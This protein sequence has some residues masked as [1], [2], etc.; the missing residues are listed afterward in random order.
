MIMKRKPVAITIPAGSSPGLT[1]TP[2]LSLCGAFNDCSA[3]KNVPNH[4]ETS[5]EEN[6]TPS[7]KESKGRHKNKKTSPSGIP[8]PSPTGRTASVVKC[9]RVNCATCPVFRPSKYFKSSLTNR[10]YQVVGNRNLSCFTSNLVY[11]ITCS[12]CDNQYVGE[13]KQKLSKRLSRHRSAI[14][15]HAYTFIAKHF[16]QPEHSVAD[17]LIQPIER[18]ELLPG[19][20]DEDVTIR[21]LDRERFWMLE[22][23]T[24][25]PYGLNDR[26]QSV[27]SLKL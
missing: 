20:S 22:L 18:I 13:T 7:S 3:T 25:Y 15:K 27:G 23:V 6:K 16:N 5:K 14:K 26:L 21:H 9:S 10:K 4:S 11:L 17:V 8:K 12:K 19:E 2:G 1:R 24:V